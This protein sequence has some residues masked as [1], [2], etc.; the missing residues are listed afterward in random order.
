MLSFQITDLAEH[1]F[2]FGY[3]IVD[4]NF[5]LLPSL[6]KLFFEMES[7][8]YSSQGK[9]FH[10]EKKHLLYNIIKFCETEA[11]NGC[12]II[13]LAHAIKRAS[14]MRVQFKKFKMKTPI[15]MIS[16]LLKRRKLKQLSKILT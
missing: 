9:H 12:E 8:Q 14:A 5:Y 2:F 15:I 6:L 7:K 3:P 16:F 1:H 13:P 4:L 11:D 10:R